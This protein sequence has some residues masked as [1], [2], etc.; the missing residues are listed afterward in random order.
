M[1]YYGILLVAILIL[2]SACEV[3]TPVMPKWDIDLAVPLINEKYYV[4]DLVNDEGTIMM[5]V[6]DSIMYLNT[7]GDVATPAF[8]LI[9]FTPPPGAV[10]DNVE[11]Y[12]VQN[13]PPQTISFEDPS[14][15]FAYAKIHSGVIQTKFTELVNN[16]SATIVFGNLFNADNS[17]YVINAVDTP[18]WV[19]WDLAGCHFGVSAIGEPFVPITDL[20]FT[21][22]S[23]S[24]AVD[25]THTGN[26]SLLANAPMEFD[27]V[28]GKLSDVVLELQESLASI[29]I[30]YPEGVNEAVTL[31]TATINIELDNKIGFD[32]EFEGQFYAYNDKTPPDI[33]TVAIKENGQ[34][35]HVSPGFNTYN[36]SGSLTE[37]LEIMPT[38]I[39]IRNGVFN[40]FSGVNPG[41]V[42]AD[43]FIGLNYVI[44][45][46]FTFTLSNHPIAIK[47]EVDIPISQ[48]NADRIN[49]NALGAK[50]EMYITNKLPV[51]ATATAYF[52]DTPN[53]DVNNIN[54]YDFPKPA[55][56]LSSLAPGGAG[57]QPVTIELTKNEIRLFGKPHVY[58]R[59]KFQFESTNGVPVTIQGRT[60]DCI[61]IKGRLKAKIAVE[62]L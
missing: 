22:T 56:I 47:N 13:I 19:V 26:L 43:D 28:E 55:T 57:E 61:H 46:P 37:L 7:V 10:F 27:E 32:A 17:N 38:H 54:T 8:G 14:V 15:Q 44:N 60:S 62:E 48:E 33:R 30:E 36:V 50:L 40:V 42:R 21:I 39:E 3:K 18:D 25:G 2:L 52:S 5:G 20:S 9:P 59:W 58:L 34:N 6:A 45:A 51:G 16:S 29:D 4:S 11:V 35:L 23:N 12:H 24:G 1:K 31:Q 53:I 49:K 41:H